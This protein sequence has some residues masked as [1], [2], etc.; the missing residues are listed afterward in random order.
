MPAVY[1]WRAVAPDGTQETGSTTATTVTTVEEL[2]RSQSLIPVEIKETKAKSSG[3]LFGF[4][5][6]TNY[7]SLIMFTSSLAT[8]NRAGIPLL[9][10]LSII[11]VGK[12]G[13]EY[14]L[15]IDAI[16]QDIQ[17]G[18]SLSEAMKKFPKL[19]SSVYTSC[20]M[21]GEE[22]G[23]LDNTLDEL[24]V[25]LEQEM[26][27]IRHIKSGL[28]YPLIV[29]GI[30][31]VAFVVLINFVIPK[32]LNF[33]STFNA[34]LPLLTRIIM[35]ISNFATSYW[36]VILLLLVAMGVALKFFLANE[37]G[38]Y[39]FDGK[40]LKMPVFGDLIIKGNVARF[41]LLF[42]VLVSSGLNVVRSVTILAATVKNTAIAAEISQMAELFRLG[43]DINVSSTDFKYF[44]NQALH[45]ISIGME[46]GN[47]DSMLR[48]VGNYYTKQVTYTSR[49]LTAIIEPILTL[50]MGIFIL[51]LALAIFLPMWNII[52]IFNH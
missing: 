8:M 2:L 16:R 33:F 19:F 29:I 40:L 32:F 26:E 21:A 17:S 4:F 23:K 36:P 47:M 37:K 3:S 5:K 39:W 48:E 9:R 34:E 28:R 7:E 15:A 46:S 10:A 13:S 51:V 11:R 35:S 27:L 30:I 44:P 14:N 49:Q 43:R 24:I 18:K 25:I 22:S 50:I 42:R 12:E 45:M 6:G 38:R 20:I 1:K 52:K 31:V 41:C